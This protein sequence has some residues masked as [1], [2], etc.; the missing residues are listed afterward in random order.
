MLQSVYPFDLG[1]LM[2]GT[3]P[4]AGCAVLILSHDIPMNLATSFEA[5][6][7]DVTD[8]TVRKKENTHRTLLSVKGELK[9]GIGLLVARSF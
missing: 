5:E 2:A 9:I 3:E 1:C 4:G 6:T 7:T 8:A